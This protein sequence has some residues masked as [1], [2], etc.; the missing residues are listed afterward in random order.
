[1]IHI[2]ENLPATMVGFVASG[3]VTQNDFTDRVMPEVKR[4][5]DKTRELN[6]LLVLDTS[7]KNF[8]LGAWFQDAIMGI[9]HLARWKRAA[10]VTDVEG[11]RVFT[12]IF[13]V[14]MPGEF[15]GFS[16]ADQQKAID[17][18]SGQVKV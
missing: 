18:V 5:V 12:D 7:I 13:S 10:I 9:R 8:S 16:H 11:I 3:E 4:L 2:L 15:K 6:Y 17:W 1:M 14:L